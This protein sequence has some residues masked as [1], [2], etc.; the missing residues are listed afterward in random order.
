MI[1]VL[2]TALF[3]CAL[4]GL[5]DPMSAHDEEDSTDIDSSASELALESPE[6]HI[7]PS[8]SGSTDNPIQ[9]TAQCV[10]CTALPFS[11]CRT[12]AIP[13]SSSHTITVMPQ[14]TWSTVEVFDVTGA[15]V[16]SHSTGWLPRG[17]R[18]IQGLFNWYYLKNT[19]RDIQITS[20]EICNNS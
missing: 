15:R 7:E 12:A 17:S 14:G 1:A 8:D 16:Y 19:A 18:T 20:E 4:D 13:A 2:S 11:S 10:S 3:G 5:E 9:I 6:G